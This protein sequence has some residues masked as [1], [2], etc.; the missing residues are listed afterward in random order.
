[1]KQKKMNMF[2]T[3]SL[4][5]TFLTNYRLQFIFTKKVKIITNLSVQYQFHNKDNK[6]NEKLYNI[7][8]K[9]TNDLN[10]YKKIYFYTNR[11][12]SSI[13]NDA[14]SYFLES[15]YEIDQLLSNK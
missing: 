5:F 7:T 8:I 10:I 6:S 4:H 1:M 15:F 3:C 12:L 2:R 14:D 9:I 11:I 13:Q